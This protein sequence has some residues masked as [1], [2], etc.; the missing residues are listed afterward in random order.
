MTTWS[1]E[2]EISIDLQDIWK[3]QMSYRVSL[4]SE[5]FKNIF[6]KYEGFDIFS[7]DQLCL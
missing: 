2:P 5:D 1:P 4:D 7:L 3:K 6:D